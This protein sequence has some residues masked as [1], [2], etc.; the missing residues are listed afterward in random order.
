[1]GIKDSKRSRKIPSK[2]HETSEGAMITYLQN[3]LFTCV[4]EI[5]WGKTQHHVE[6]LSTEVHKGEYF[7]HNKLEQVRGFFVYISRTY[8]ATTQYLK[9]NMLP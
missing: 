5:K 1:M 7:N 8:P 3:E 4:Y 6:W 9:G 2:T